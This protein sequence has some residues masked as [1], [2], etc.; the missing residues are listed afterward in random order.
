MCLSL[1]PG[2]APLPSRKTILKTITA[3]MLIRH[4]EISAKLRSGRE[5]VTV[6]LSMPPE[7]HVPYIAPKEFNFQRAKE[8]VSYDLDFWSTSSQHSVLGV[9]SQTIDA[10]TFKMSSTTLAVK[11]FDERHL[12]ENIEKAIRGLYKDLG[13]PLESSTF[14]RAVLD[15]GSDVNSAMK[16]IPTPKNNCA[17]HALHNAVKEA[18]NMVQECSMVTAAGK[19][20]CA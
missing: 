13:A 7:S 4:E 3:M 15:K 6:P 1:N 8:Y 12:A 10:Q 20:V 14:V 9:T 5:L 18:L 11:G 16:G 19:K 17:A 2:V